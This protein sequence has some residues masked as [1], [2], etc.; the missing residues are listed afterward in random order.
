MLTLRTYALALVFGLAIAPLTRAQDPAPQSQ[1]P[2]PAQEP[3][4]PAQPL[5]P[6]KSADTQGK[7]SPDDQPIFPVVAGTVVD[8]PLGGA[9]MPVIGLVR[10]RSY[11]V[12]AVSYY[13]V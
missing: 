12:P 8:A 1:N 4:N 7:S 9:A 3:T 6:D 11:V 13:G 2:P 5:P 10:S